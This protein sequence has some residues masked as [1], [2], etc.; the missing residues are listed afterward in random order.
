M[1]LAGTAKS[2]RI[3]QSQHYEEDRRAVLH[4]R[5]AHL[6]YGSHIQYEELII[7]NGCMQLVRDPSKFDAADGESLA[8][9]PARAAVSGVGRRAGAIR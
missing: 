5:Q 1:P 2:D 8:I 3:S 6:R 4:A 9:S 7:D